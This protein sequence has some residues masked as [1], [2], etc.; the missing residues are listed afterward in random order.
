MTRQTYGQAIQDFQKAKRRA[1]LQTFLARW[2]GRSLDLL[3]YDEVKQQ[4]KAYG[5]R[6]VGLRQIALDAIVGSVGRYRDFN[7]NFLPRIEGDQSRWASVKAAQVE[8]GLPP[9][10]VYQIGDAYFVLDGNHR[11]SVAREMG[12]KTIEAYVTEVKTRVPLTPDD[13]PA[14]IILKAEYADFLAC[15]QLDELKPDVNLRLTSPGKYPLLLEHI[16]VHRFY[17]GRE[18]SREIPYDEAVIHWCE[19]VYLPTVRLIRE[20]GL[21]RDF[22]ERTEA[23][24]YVWLADHRA[25]V[26]E[27]LGWEVSTELAVVDMAANFGSYSPSSIKGRALQSVLIGA[28]E[29]NEADRQWQQERLSAIGSQPFLKT[30]LLP[31]SGKETIFMASLPWRSRQSVRRSLCGRCS[32]NLNDVVTTKVY[33]PPSLW[34]RRILR[35]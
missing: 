34:K 35:N 24:M 31:L 17:M 16:E 25:E 22:P 4:L 27:M 32:L 11:V 29:T 26:E 10:D 30:L 6:E 19:Q 2:R 1:G 13:E 3:S 33:R 20:T 7:R 28:Q 9:I 23:D 15:T 5:M 18:Q 21:I 12:S 14:D 8:Q